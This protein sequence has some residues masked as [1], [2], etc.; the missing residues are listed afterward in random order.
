LP[1]KNGQHSFFTALKVLLDLQ[2]LNV[3]TTGIKTYML[4]LAKAARKYPHPEIEWIFTHDPEEQASIKKEIG[5]RTKVQKLNYHLDYFRWKQFQLPDLVKKYNPDVLICLDFVSPAASLPCKRLTVIHDAFFWQIPENYPKWWRKYFLN[6]IRKGLRENTQ[7]ITTTDY[8]KN[9]L[10]QYLGNSWPISVIYQ[11]SKALSG[12]A[13]VHFLQKNA[14]PKLGY[15]LH[16]GTFDRRKNLPLLVQA[17]ADYLKKSNRPKKMVLAGGAGQSQQLNDLPEVKR[18]IASLGLEQDILL[19][20]Y[21]TDGEIKSLY[22]GA[23]AYL[24]PSTNEGFG[25]PILEAMTFGLPVIHSD[26]AALAEVAGGAGL[27]F[28]TS[29]VNDLTEKMILLEEDATLR[30]NLILHGK[31]RVKEF[32][33]EKF[34]NAFHRLILR[35]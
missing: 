34:I 26:Q 1:F 32:T 11:T 27:S 9:C 30:T 18:I 23:F 7:I 12:A 5:P 16:I 13:D 6:L 3:A 24:F 8:S 4:E 15:F 14:L 25:I 17:Y 29:S 21:L 28:Q 2:Y 10:Q 35:A 22:E 31:E 33:A 19:P 20:G